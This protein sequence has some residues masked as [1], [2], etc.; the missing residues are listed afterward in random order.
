MLFLCSIEFVLHLGTIY[1]KHF[2]KLLQDGVDKLHTL[3]EKTFISYFMA[4]PKKVERD[5]ATLI[6]DVAWVVLVVISLPSSC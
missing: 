3:N 4:H 2:N 5:I 6:K 1:I